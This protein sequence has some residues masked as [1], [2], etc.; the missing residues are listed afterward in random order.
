VGED[1][2]DAVDRDAAGDEALSCVEDE[3]QI[4]G[5]DDMYEDPFGDEDEAAFTTALSL[6]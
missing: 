6:N 4:L 5:E 1:D 2:D 3:V